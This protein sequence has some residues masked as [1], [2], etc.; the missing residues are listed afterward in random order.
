MK[1][2]HFAEMVFIQ[3]KKYGN[4]NAL[5]YRDSDNSWTG[6]SWNEFAI[7]VKSISKA[8]SDIGVIY[9]NNIGIY[10]QNKPESFVIDFAAFAIKAVSVPMYATSTASQIEY[11][12]N[13]ALIS[14]I[15]VGEQFQYDNAYEVMSTSNSLKKI[16]IFDNT[17]VTHGEESTIYFS[18]F[19]KMGQQSTSHFE[20][21]D[22]QSNVT[23][24]QLA[25]IMYTS[26]TTGEPKVV[27]LSHGN[28]LEAMRIN[29]MRLI[30][31]TDKDKSIVFLPITHIFERTWCYFCL[32]KGVEIYINLHPQEI[33]KTIKEVRPTLMCSVPRFWEK[34]YNGVLQNIESYNPLMQGI[35]TWAV[36]VGSRYNIDYIRLEK[37]P[38][39]RLKVN[40]KIADRFILSK[41]K[42][43][44]GIENANFLPV[45]GATL[46]EDIIMFFRSIGI[47][48]LYGYG[49]TETTATVSCFNYT[50]YK[51]GTVG[52]IMPE[53]E[54]KIGI[55]NEILV[56]GKTVFQGYYKKP[57]IN[58][59]SFTDDGFFKTGDAG[60]IE[61]NELILTER[62]KDLFKTSNGKYIAPQQLETILGVDKY[63]D[64]VAVIGDQR[65]F[66]SA[67]I[68]PDMEQLKKYA[69]KE[70]ID[71][72]NLDN[73]LKDNRI[74]YFYMERI[75]TL[76]EGMAGFEQIKR[77]TLIKKS[78]SIEA[79]E[80]TNT[81]KLRRAVILHKYKKII[82]HMYNDNLS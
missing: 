18:E 43:T 57:E 22:I 27:M 44:L 20:I 69:Q 79:G 54:V 42:K 9:Q 74:L 46:S 4:K 72:E 63:I 30:T 33:Q 34:V 3:A 13:D 25:T 47:P 16:I 82:D 76:Q 67:I 5:W 45:A 36:V 49:L 26:G 40:Y 65:S 19:L 70:N 17:V 80:L 64:Q 62:I 56:K 38:T 73:L 6:L 48:I 8:L 61:N 32:Y 14:V 21:E 29:D 51:I 37:K 1:Y 24:E 39:F 23:A 71:Y 7:Q 50:H 11:I 68:I 60:Y 28:Y 10:S 75:K 77:I 52:E 12:V 66:V 55:D 35:V 41:V 58:E 81:L 31:V 53:L 2:P 59:G 15:F 78:F